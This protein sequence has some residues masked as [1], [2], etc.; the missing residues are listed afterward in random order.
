MALRTF[1][2]ILGLLSTL[3]F[4][5]ELMAQPI[6]PNTKPP[7]ATLGGGHGALP[8]E[9]R[10]S[11]KKLEAPKKNKKGHYEMSWRHFRDFDQKKKRPGK[12]LGTAINQKIKIK[13]FMIPLDYESKSIKEFLLVPYVPSCSHVPPPPQ[14][15]IIAV[16]AAS[17]KGFPLSYYPVEVEGKLS[18]VKNPKQSD[19][20]MPSGLFSLT[21]KKLKEVKQ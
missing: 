16:K 14:N 19:P 5:L 12:I 3:S 4:G 10:P 8:A 15:M 2:K 11:D 13:G 7:S 6:R 1:M 17:K 9:L 21:A 18:M 20:F